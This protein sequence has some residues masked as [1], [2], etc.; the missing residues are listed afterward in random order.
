[1]VALCR[2][3]QAVYAELPEVDAAHLYITWRTW[4]LWCVLVDMY[5]VEVQPVS[6][7]IRANRRMAI[8]SSVADDLASNAYRPCPYSICYRIHRGEL[9]PTQ[10]H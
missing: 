2:I 8:S 9:L 7:M 1:M 6:R 4:S 10:G 5:G 3:R